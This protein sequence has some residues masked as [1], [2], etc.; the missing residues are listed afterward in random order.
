MFI[1]LFWK[2]LIN[3]CEVLMMACVLELYLI[4]YVGY[5]DKYC[6]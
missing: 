6:S 1:L 5:A 4:R 2:W 3:F